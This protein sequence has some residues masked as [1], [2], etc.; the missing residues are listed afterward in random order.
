MPIAADRENAEVGQ[1]E[2]EHQ[3]KNRAGDFGCPGIFLFQGDGEGDA[4]TQNRQ[5]HPGVIGCDQ[6]FTTEQIQKNRTKHRNLLWKKL[7]EL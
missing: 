5:Q 1:N 3:R 2:G 7:K 6:R 4:E